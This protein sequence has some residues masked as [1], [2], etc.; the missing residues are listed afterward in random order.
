MYGAVFRMPYA[1]NMQPSKTTHEQEFIVLL[2]NSILAVYVC[3]LLSFRVQIMRFSARRVP[4]ILAA[5]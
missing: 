5:I 2:D 3:I 4:A 1:R